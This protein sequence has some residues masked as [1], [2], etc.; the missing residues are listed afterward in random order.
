MGG[1]N[2]LFGFDDLSAKDKAVKS[3][4]RQFARL[5]ASVVSVDIP[6]TIKRK[7]GQTYREVNLTFADSQTV[8][9]AVKK[10]GDIFEVRLNK[11][12]IPI[13]GQDDQI[14][15]LSEI[16][17][18]M[19]AGRAA[20][21]KKLAAVKIPLP[22]GVKTT[23]KKKSEAQADRITELKA[24]IEEA[25]ARLRAIRADIEANRAEILKLTEPQANA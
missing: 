12:P 5:G 23:T 17:D 24:L 9:L 3:I 13:K 15:A 1:Q 16:V 6:T 21:Q 14:K 11:K 19:N 18:A 4:Q 20:F 22:S 10:T 2:I 25:K 7:A 8:T